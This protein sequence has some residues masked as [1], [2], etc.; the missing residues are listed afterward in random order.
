MKNTA[1]L[2]DAKARKAVRDGVNAIYEPVKRTLG[3]QAKTA[4]IYRTYNRGSRI[5]DDGVTVAEVQEPKNPFVRLVADTFKE[6]CKRTVEK[7]GDGTTTT[8]VIGGK[9][10]NDVYAILDGKSEF[11]GAGSTGSADLRRQI[12][13][14]AEK[15]KAEI[16]KRSTKVTT[17][18]ELE[19]VSII[20]V[21]DETLGKIVAK[22]AWDVGVDGFIDVVEGYKGEIET[23]IIQGFRFQAKPAAKAFVNNPKR[24][25]MVAVDCPVLLTNHA[26]DS[27][28]EIAPVLSRLNSGGISKIIVI[29]PSFSENVLVNMVN[30]V[31]AGYFIFPVAVPGMRTEQ[32]EDLA[33]YAGA[34]FIDKNKGRKFQNAKVEDLGFMEKLIV[35]D[36]DM[37]EEAV[38]TGG[39]GTQEIMGSKEEDGET[40]TFLTTAVKQR[41]ETL[42]SQMEE[43]KQDNFKKL[44]ERRIASMSSAVGII[45]VGESTQASA[46]YRKLKIEDCVYAS[47]AALRGGYSKGGGLELKE[48]TEEIL[49]EKDILRAALL[50]PY[51]LIQASVPGG[52][53]ITDEIIDP[54]EAIFWAVEHSTSVV[55]Q[56]ATVEVLTPEIDEMGPGDGYMAIARMVGEMSIIMK[57][58]LG[59]LTESQEEAERD[60]LGGISEGEKIVLDNG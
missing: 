17:L 41:V 16:L 32:F 35:K 14:S 27:A 24:Y 22:M 28:G 47:K 53:E 26:L 15:V 44:F 21:K 48:I 19:R 33:V 40:K 9:L 39:K 58:H 12:L 10:Y 31:K 55:A 36:T 4:L 6:M 18:E 57:R 37:R 13:A 50:H 20:S 5:T 56:L 54:T 29:A 43:Q 49:D 30:A 38:A 60:R 52:I 7:V 46:L 23:E 8:A 59:Q 25:E 42:K 3:P 34:E 1:T 2:L 51:E 45:R 11:V